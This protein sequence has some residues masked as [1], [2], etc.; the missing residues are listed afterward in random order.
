VKYQTPILKMCS[1]NTVPWYDKSVN[2]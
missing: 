1:I 2:I